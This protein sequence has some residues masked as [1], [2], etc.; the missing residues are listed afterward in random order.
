MEAIVAWLKDIAAGLT[1]VIFIGSSFV[2]T[3]VTHTVFTG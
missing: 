1:F 2:L 3:T